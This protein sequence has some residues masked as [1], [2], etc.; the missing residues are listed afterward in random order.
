ILVTDGQPVFQHAAGYLGVEQRRWQYAE[1]IDEDQQIFGTGMQNL[2]DTG[3]NQQCRERFPGLDTKRIDE[4]NVFTITD[5]EQ[6]GIRIEGGYPHEFG[7]ECQRLAVLPVPAGFGQRGIGI[8]V[9]VTYG[10]FWQS[11]IHWSFSCTGMVSCCISWRPAS[12]CV[13][14]E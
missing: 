12:E 7:I 1:K 8:N 13:R 6:R 3:I 11:F 10:R 2:D 5:L 14:V 9:T 4:N